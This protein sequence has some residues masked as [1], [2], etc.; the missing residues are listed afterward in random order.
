MQFVLMNTILMLAYFKNPKATI[1]LIAVFLTVTTIL[2][3]VISGPLPSSVKTMISEQTN[4]YFRST[5]AH[6][7]FY[8]IGMLFGLVSD[9]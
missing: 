9:K 6:A 5:Y 4:N 7:P 3:F 1:G 2:M 8:F